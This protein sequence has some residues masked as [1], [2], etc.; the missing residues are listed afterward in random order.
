MS[1]PARLGLFGQNPPNFRAKMI[2][3]IRV[4]AIGPPFEPRRRIFRLEADQF[5]EPFASL[6][7]VIADVVLVD[8]TVEG[9]EC[10]L[11]APVGA[12]QILFGLFA[13]G[14]LLRHA[15]DLQG[16]PVR[17]TYEDHLAAGDPSPL[18][19]AMLHP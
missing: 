13:F 7:G 2:A 3:V 11:V 14:Y 4:N 19:V 8:V 16:P 6:G 17:V 18:A 10:D 9:V 12:L 15:Q 1:L 5:G